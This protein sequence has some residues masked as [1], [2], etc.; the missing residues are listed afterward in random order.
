MLPDTMSKRHK[1]LAAAL[2]L[3]I[4]ASSLQ[5]QISPAQQAQIAAIANKILADT[6]VPSAS[7]GIVVNGKIAYMQAFGLAQISP[8]I[9]ARA[10]MPYPIGSVS[11]QFTATAILLLQQQGRLSIDDP[12]AKYFP[13]LTRAN[14]VRLRDLMTMTS[15]YEDFAPQDYSIPAWY[16]PRRPIDTV[17]EWATKP[18][19]FAPGTDHQYSNT[20]YV[21]LALILEKV[22]GE[23]YMQA[24]NRLVLGPAGLLPGPGNAGAFNGY[25]HRDRLP[26]LGYQSIA[27]QAPRVMPLE[28]EGWYFGDGELAMSTATLLKW[29][30]TFIN[31][32]LLSPASYDQMETPTLL[33]GPG[34]GAGKNTHYGLGIY[35]LDRNG[36]QEIE[37]SGEVGGYVSENIV[38]P[39]DKLAIVVLTNE[40]ASD[41]AGDIADAI[42][43]ILLPAAYTPPTA[44][45][46]SDPVAAQ[47]P[48]ILTGLA[49]GELDRSLFTANCNFYF[50]DA[51]IADFQATL[52]P[53]GTVQKVIRTSTNH[54][55]GMLFGLYKVTFS[56]GTTLTLDTYT[57][58]NGRIEQLLILSKS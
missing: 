21:L 41:A 50:S 23:P 55:G 26:A 48:T 45:P 18:L 24:L 17:M 32:S 39:Q 49:H 2:F 37:H 22:T 25:A 29:D 40:V 47:L 36:H 43:H 10:D 46:P 58:P 57:L 28:A 42:G 9:A 56:G 8:A 7:I 54:R 16:Q 38:F 15:G 5:A 1:L 12:V 3:A 14:E 30:L 31:R 19:D 13:Q 6:G 33:T 35:D 4:A 51:A 27:L 34:P 53:L 20:N 11:K 52:A 44:A